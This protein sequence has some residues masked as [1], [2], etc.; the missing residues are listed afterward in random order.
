MIS[1]QKKKKD[2][3]QSEQS[4]FI[5]IFYFFAPRTLEND[6]VMAKIAKQHW[7]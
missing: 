7:H 5:I 6:Q 1:K 3:R 2:Q 4:G